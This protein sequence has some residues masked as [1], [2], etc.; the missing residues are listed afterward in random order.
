MTLDQTLVYSAQLRDLTV[1]KAA[2]AELARSTASF[3]TVFDH[4]LQAMALISPTGSVLEMN[5]AAMDLL[6]PGQ[7]V[8]GSSFSELPFWSVDPEATAN[9]L[10]DA[11][12]QCQR[13]RAYRSP[14]NMR[15][16]DGSQRQLDFSLSPITREGEIFAMVAEVREMSEAVSPGA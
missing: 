3:H 4:A 8:L 6:P 2:Q 1:R 9:W 16:P 11:M 13:G 14:V 10:C 15:M 5:P 7:Q 12:A